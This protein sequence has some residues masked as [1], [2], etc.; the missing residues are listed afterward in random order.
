MLARLSTL[1]AQ[2]IQ[3]CQTARN[4]HDPAGAA[5]QAWLRDPAACPHEVCLSCPPGNRRAQGMPGARC[6]RSLACESEKH[7]SKSPQVHRTGPAF[8]ARWFY[9]LFRALPGERALLPPSSP[10]SLLPRNLTPASRRQG[11]TASPSARPVLRLLLSPRV[12]RCPASL[13]P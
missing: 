6:T 7:A 2:R 3:R 13:R 8:P 5:P 12:H 11:H 9:G 10:G 4:P 1:R